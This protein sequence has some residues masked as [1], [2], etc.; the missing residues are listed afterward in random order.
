M[1]DDFDRDFYYNSNKTDIL[2]VAVAL[3]ATIFIHVGAYY[4]VPQEF[5]KFGEEEKKYDDLKIP[6]IK[7]LKNTDVLIIQIMAL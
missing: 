6:I 7:F 3:I 4:V 2:A 1:Q 5:A